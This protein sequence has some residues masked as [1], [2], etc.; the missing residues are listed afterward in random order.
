MFESFIF[1]VKL[2]KK[3]INCPSALATGARE[4]VVGVQGIHEVVHLKSVKEISDGKYAIFY[5]CTDDDKDKIA[6]AMTAL[7]AEEV[8]EAEAIQL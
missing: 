7:G 3:C 8:R 1:T 5:V 4:D 6:K 2:S